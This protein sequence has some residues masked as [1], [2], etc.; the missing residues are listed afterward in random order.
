MLSA[1]HGKSYSIYGH[2]SN[3]FVPDLGRVFDMDF[4]VLYKKEK[5]EMK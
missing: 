2:F 5:R 3:L 4:S 1:V